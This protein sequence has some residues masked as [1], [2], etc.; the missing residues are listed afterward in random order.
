MK[1]TTS[2]KKETIINNKSSSSNQEI[3]QINENS[4]ENENKKD[5]KSLYSKK[6]VLKKNIK[7]LLPNPNNNNNDIDQVQNKDI[8]II[9]ENNMNNSNELINSN[10]FNEM[11][12]KEKNKNL[13]KNKNEKNNEQKLNDKNEEGYLDEDLEDDDNKK[14]YLRVIK[15]MEKTYGVPIIAAKIP[16]EPI[17]DIEME[18]NIRPILINSDKKNINNNPKQIYND[19]KNNINKKNSKNY[20][21]NIGINNNNKKITRPEN[22]RYAYDQYNNNHNNRINNNYNINYYPKEIGQNKSNNFPYNNNY[23]N[24]INRPRKYI[25]MTPNVYKYNNCINRPKQYIS[26]S[27]NKNYNNII[28]KPQQYDYKNIINRPHPYSYISQNKCNNINSPRQ[29]NINISSTTYNINNNK[30]P[31][32]GYLYQKEQSYIPNRNLSNFSNIYNKNNI[33]SRVDST[34][35]PLSNNQPKIY[36]NENTIINLQKRYQKETPKFDNNKEYNSR[37]QGYINNKIQTRDNKNYPIPIKNQ[38]YICV[39]KNLQLYDNMQNVNPDRYDNNM[40]KMYY[41]CQNRSNIHQYTKGKQNT[42]DLNKNKNNNYLTNSLINSRN[43]IFQKRT[44]IPNYRE[45]YNN[46]IN[47]LKN[48]YYSPSSYLNNRNYG[49][50][51]NN[52][53]NKKRNIPLNKSHQNYTIKYN[54]KYNEFI[55]NNNSGKNNRNSNQIP[56]FR[57]QNNINNLKKKLD[58]LSNNYIQNNKKDFDYDICCFERYDSMPDNEECIAYCIGPNFN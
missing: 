8:E 53:I 4:Q 47:Y 20:I 42:S 11:K 44:D 54:N 2:I 51:T 45:I 13:S 14:I 15:R 56:L 55:Q 32:Y 43:P 34:K 12:D 5:D 46:R 22:Q 19:N 30:N 58:N 28:N 26:I 33:I 48:K 17:E 35:R 40:R 24:N 23:N 18:E 25:P 16:G 39:G 7:H 57:S 52:Q 1:V 41:L 27:Q 3:P 6:V 10:N 29:N 50:I 36:T 49:N 21:N 9:N 38:S 37:Y 31:Q